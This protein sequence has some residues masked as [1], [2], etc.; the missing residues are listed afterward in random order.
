MIYPYMR[1]PGFEK[2]VDAFL[3]EKL[4]LPATLNNKLLNVDPIP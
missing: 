4:N 2:L 1:S 3:A